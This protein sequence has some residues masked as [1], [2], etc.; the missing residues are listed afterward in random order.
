VSPQHERGREAE[1]GTDEEADRE[2]RH[3]DDAINR[4]DG[5]T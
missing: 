2:G 1:R 5:K 3:V 4:A